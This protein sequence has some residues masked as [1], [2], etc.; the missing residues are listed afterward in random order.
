M[1]ETPQ[2]ELSFVR[3]PSH[4]SGGRLCFSIPADVAELL[5][6]DA[7]YQVTVRPVGTLTN[8][9]WRP[10]DGEKRPQDTLER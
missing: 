3:R 5:H 6:S 7:K 10:A 4:I 9:H 1:N 2:D 8:N